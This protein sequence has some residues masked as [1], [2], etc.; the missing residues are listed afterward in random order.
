MTAEHN[1]FL[2]LLNPTQKKLQIAEL[3]IKLAGVG[4]S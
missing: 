1:A 3:E 2:Q 4:L